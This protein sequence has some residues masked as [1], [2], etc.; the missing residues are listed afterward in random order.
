MDGDGP[1]WD[2]CLFFLDSVP[3]VVVVAVV[4]V[5]VG[6][7]FIS[8]LTDAVVDEPGA[9]VV[10]SVRAAA[11]GVVVVVV[12]DVVV[13]VV[14]VS[15]STAIGDDL[16]VS[17]FLRG[18]FA[19]PLLPSLFPPLPP[20]VLELVPALLLLLVRMHVAALPLGLTNI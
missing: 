14:E 4:V 17:F 3:A 15:F 1:C 6:T 5:G 8:G 20:P 13:V 2:G 9:F 7:V 16:A 18:R 11:E 12:A 10:V 19:P